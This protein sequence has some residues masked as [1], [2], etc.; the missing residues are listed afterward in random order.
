MSEPKFTARQKEEVARRARHCCEYCQSQAR[1]SPDPFSIEH[2]RPRSRGGAI[3]PSNLALSCQGCN[4]HKYTS[5]EAV[6]PVTGESVS[7][8][9]PRK[10]KWGDH[11]IW[12]EDYTLILGRTP[13]GRATIEKLK[14]NRTGLMNLRRVLHGIGEHPVR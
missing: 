6:D 10:Q 12:N 4:S 2:I 11:F 1:F 13:M 3:D 8:F 9:H 14:L 7:L 5:T